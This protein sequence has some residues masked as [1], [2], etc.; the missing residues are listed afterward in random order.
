MNPETDILKEILENFVTIGLEEIENIGLMNR[1]DTKYILPVNLLPELLKRMQSDYRVLVINEKRVTGYTTR[2]FDTENFLFFNQHVTGRPER[3]KIR[4]RTY[5][6][7]GET[8]LEIKM[9]QRNRRTVKWRILNNPGQIGFDD[10]A[11]EFLNEHISVS[12]QDLRQVIEG[13]LKRITLAGIKNHEKIT[14]DFSLNYSGNGS[15]NKGF[16]WL[17]VAEWKRDT[18]KND[19]L[20]PYIIKNFSLHSSG[21]SKYC[22]GCALIYDLQKKNLLKPKF[23]LLNKIENEY[24]RSVNS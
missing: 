18:L 20:F 7:T 8:F 16:P 24:S 2:Y 4:Y 23:Q 6:S 10:T 22:M 12:Y 17:A 21:F 3:Y 14:I 5:D 9:K 1:V 11:I 13:T 15:E 19:S